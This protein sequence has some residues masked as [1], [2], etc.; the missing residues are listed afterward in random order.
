M[1]FI[2]IFGLPAL[3]FGA[4]AMLAQPAA[5]QFG[6]SDGSAFAVVE[7]FTSGAAQAVP[8]RTGCWQKS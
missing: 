3:F 7:L 1:K 8:L 4:V 6:E 5:G 2:L